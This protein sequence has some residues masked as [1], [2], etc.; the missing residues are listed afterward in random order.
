[1][2]P[3]SSLSGLTRENSIFRGTEGYWAEGT[4]NKCTEVCCSG[5]RLPRPPPCSGGRKATLWIFPFRSITSLQL[6]TAG[7]QSLFLCSHSALV[8]KGQVPT[9]GAGGGCMPS[10]HHS[11]NCQD[12]SEKINSTGVPVMA[13]R[14]RI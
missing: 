11:G 5:T 14:K 2:I 9:Q 10:E 8:G 4:H 13:Q 1:M 12:L 3:E 7:M 6:G